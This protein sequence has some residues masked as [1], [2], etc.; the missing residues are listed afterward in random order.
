MTASRSQGA[1]ALSRAQE[2]V[3]VRKELCGARTRIKALEELSEAHHKQILDIRDEREQLVT[4]L[5]ASAVEYNDLSNG[6]RLEKEE[7][8]RLR[9]ALK[10]ASQEDVVHV[11]SRLWRCETELTKARAENA[12]LLD[13][14]KALTNRIEA[15][16][17]DV[18]EARLGEAT[19]IA[20]LKT[21]T[22]FRPGDLAE[23]RRDIYELKK[24]VAEKR[25]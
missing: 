3:S 4:R 8:A 21:A 12:N 19:L 18:R 15:I 9:E 2:L 10:E 20:V 11:G 22:V 23:L 7:S 13:E 17:I 16:E 25:P 5:R 14:R 1:T 24:V 6:L